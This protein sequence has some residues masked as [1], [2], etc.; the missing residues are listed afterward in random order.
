MPHPL[1]QHGREA[2]ARNDLAA[3]SAA[4]EERLRSDARDIEALE[5]RYLIHVRRGDIAKAAETLHAVITITPQAD[6][7]FNN[8]TSLLFSNGRRADAEQVARAALR[9][10]AGNAQGHNLFGTI[11]S[12]LNDLTSGE[13]HF[14]RA[15][16][17]AGPQAPVLANLALNLMQQGRAEEAD[18]YFAQADAL[19]PNTMQTL[20]H[21]SKLC[22]VR[23]DLARA[24]ALLSRAEA[25]SS[26]DEV[27]LL[28]AG[29]LARAGK[30]EDALSLIN[31]APSMS[32]Q[33]RL[34]R[35]R[36]L[37]KLGRHNDAWND[38]VEAKRQLAKEGGGIEYKSDVVQL[39]CS[40]LQHFFVRAKIELLPTAS[41]RRDAP[42]PIFIIGF[43]RSG[44]TL[45][46]QILSSH[47]AVAAGG[48]LVFLGETRRLAN[49]LLPGPD[50]FPENLA[51]SWT[52]DNRHVAALFRD[53]YLARA[54]QSGLFNTGKPLFTDK[55]PFN[56]M[57]LPLLKM[58]F[59]RAKIVRVARHPLDVC[60]SMMSNNLT[61]GFNCGYRIEDTVRHFA[62][63]FE[64]LEHY[65]R[66]MTI[67]DY[68]LRYERLVREPLAEIQKLLEYLELPFEAACMR[69]HES[70]RYA[71][72]PS[73][74]QVTEPLNDKSINR[75]KHYAEQLK[76]FV[77]PL[78]PMLRANGY[79]SF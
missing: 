65:R 36:L 41:V 64:L 29:Y 8:L 3:T 50:P 75:Y 33:G 25:A 56:E 63:M 70:R 66:E 48:E 38:F 28:R 12:E 26:K 17:L 72:T 34:E 6:W 13:W 49:L 40:R 27:D 46:E 4:A 45:V 71:P 24:E 35:G 19:A 39:F 78:A 51:Q 20:A 42:Q 47:S 43:P 76:P 1:V 32:G 61:H 54:E 53:H 58:A 5:L 74:A 69:F 10:N 11:L 16:A 44:T 18:A 9:A 2:L 73:Y 22:E 52:A 60:V 21:W 31:A 37:D 68:E 15:L 67:N 55:M 14:R 57:Y 23:G 77:E 7:A 30:L 79:D 62:A 59:P